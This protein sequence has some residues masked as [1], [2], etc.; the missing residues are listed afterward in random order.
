MKKF[1][2]LISAGCAGFIYQLFIFGVGLSMISDSSASP[3]AAARATNKTAGTTSRAKSVPEHPLRVELTEVTRLKSQTSPGVQLYIRNVGDRPITN[4]L[5]DAVWDGANRQKRPLATGSVL[6]KQTIQ[7]GEAGYVTVD[8]RI[9]ESKL[10]RTHGLYDL[11]SRE[12]FIKMPKEEQ[13]ALARTVR[14]MAVD[15]GKL[16][17]ELVEF[18]FSKSPRYTLEVDGRPVPFDLRDGTLQN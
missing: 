14:R 8:A 18:A 17:R 15:T 12:E 10:E 11:T 6:L 9:D 2:I 1:A 4:L 16:N 7:P 13:D 3:N 5:V